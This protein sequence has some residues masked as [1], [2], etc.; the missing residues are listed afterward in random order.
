MIKSTPSAAERGAGVFGAAFGL[1]V[2]FLLLL[3]AVQLL[4]GLYATSVVTGA[5]Y[6]AAR[7]VAGYANENDRAT[8]ARAAEAELRTRLGGYDARDLELVWGD[9]ADPDQITLTI[10][11][12]HPSAWPRALDPIGLT[13]VTRTI[14]VRPEAVG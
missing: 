14:T 5:A 6:D 11:A 2:F 1:L 13:E 12:V 10:H 7:E 9:L 8:A 4:L 3:F